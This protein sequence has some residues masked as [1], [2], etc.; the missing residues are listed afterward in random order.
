MHQLLVVDPKW[1]EEA[2]DSLKQKLMEK[3]SSAEEV[4]KKFRRQSEYKLLKQCHPNAWTPSVL[5]D[6]L[7]GKTKNT[8]TGKQII[9]MLSI[10]ISSDRNLSNGLKLNRCY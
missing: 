1:V 10:D 2:N 8:S 3:M 5:G 9:F 6:I 4:V 7:S